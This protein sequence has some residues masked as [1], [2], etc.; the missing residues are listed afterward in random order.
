MTPGW[1]RGAG[2][3]GGGFAALE[4]LLRRVAG[5]SRLYWCNS[6]RLAAPSTWGE[7]D[8]APLMV[9]FTPFDGGFAPLGA[10]LRRVAGVSHL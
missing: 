9:Q 10:L 1:E 3:T 7:L 6:P 2:G 4:A 5:V 8:R